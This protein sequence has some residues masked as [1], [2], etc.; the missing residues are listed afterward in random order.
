MAMKLGLSFWAALVCAGPAMVA[1]NVISG[2]DDVT[3]SDDDDGSGNGGSTAQGGTTTAGNGGSTTNST[4]TSGVGGAGSGG[5]GSGGM[6]PQPCVYPSGPYGVAQGQTV[7][8]TLSWQGYLPGASTPT[9]ITM[10]SFLDCDGSRGIDAL[11]VDT[12][13]YG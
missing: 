13:Q 5:Q 4:T 12:S 7:P 10:D 8:P 2:A 9:T 11:V 1:C 3:F 6:P